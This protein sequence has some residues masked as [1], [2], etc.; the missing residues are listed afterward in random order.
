MYIYTNDCTKILESCLQV[1]LADWKQVYLFPQKE[2][3]IKE[4]HQGQLH[5]RLPGSSRRISY[6]QLKKG[7]QKKQIIIQEELY[8]LPF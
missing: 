5:Y 2:L 7:L 1:G 8:L 3:M 4:I 6:K